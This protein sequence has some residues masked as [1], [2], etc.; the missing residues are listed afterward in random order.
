MIPRL[1]E[2]TVFEKLLSLRKIIV[3]LG[4]RQVGKTTLLDSLSKKLE[5]KNKSILYL[6]CDLEEERSSIDTTSLTTLKKL[7]AGLDYVFIDEAQRLKNPGLT[8]KIIHDNIP[9]IKIVATGSS[10]FNLKNKLSDALTGRYIDYTLYPLSS[11]EVLSGIKKSPNQVL[12]K[13]Q[14]DAILEEV[15]LSGLYPE[16]YLA[17]E[18]EDKE[19]Y[20]EKVIESY[21]FKD[22]LTFQKIRHPQVIRELTQALAYQIGAEV[23]E[24]EL[25]NRL[26]ID[27][28]TVINYLNILEQS[29]VIIR[30]FPYSR[31]PRREIGKKYKI[32]FIDVGV[33]NA[34]IGDFN[35]I[36][37][38]ADVGPLWENFLIIERIK[39]YANKGQSV[40]YHFW[41]SYG[42]AE[43]DYL[44]RL[45][46]LKKF[47]AFEIKYTQAAMSKG[48][49]LFSKKYNIPVRVVNKANYLKFIQGK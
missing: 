39:A 3:I 5:T 32:Y 46:T 47:S 16:I 20:L 4:A 29:F 35:S 15:M 44:E 36:R 33:R 23:N 31:N 9:S 22:I 48:A 1:I 25:A 6:N 45:S 8:L 13:K 40:R 11:V 2:D 41:R 17:R 14:A 38:R 18:H 21:L 26:K 24:N 28:K 30:V 43:V 34:L 19:L 37:V 10:S 27:R 12:L 49:K 42:G 7:M